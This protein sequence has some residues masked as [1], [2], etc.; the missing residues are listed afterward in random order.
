M[1]DHSP[2][3]KIAGLFEEEP[4]RPALSS[5][6]EQSDIGQVF[7]QFSKETQHM[8]K[9]LEIDLNEQ[10]ARFDS[11][12]LYDPD[13]DIGTFGENVKDRLE[14]D[15]REGWDKLLQDSHK[16]IDDINDDFTTL[17][18]ETSARIWNSLKPLFR[19]YE[20]NTEIPSPEDQESFDECFTTIVF[21][22][23]GKGKTAPK[24]ALVSQTELPQHGP[25]STRQMFLSFFAS[26]LQRKK[27]DEDD[28]LSV[29]SSS[30]DFAGGSSSPFQ[31][32][33]SIASMNVDPTASV[34]STWSQ[35]YRNSSSRRSSFVSP[36]S[37]DSSRRGSV[38]SLSRRS[39]QKSMGEE[40][41]RERITE[42]KNKIKDALQEMTGIYKK[43]EKDDETVPGA[44]E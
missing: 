1:T 21:D 34:F 40:E 42:Q 37:H 35:W 43:Y 33:D 13:K 38:A 10:A 19:L 28:P 6:A 36:K 11:I 9:G 3:T 12:P 23:I 26:R 2:S 18:P 14:D 27:K 4:D 41:A 16:C 17:D 31:R 29:S 7:E 5:S 24:D 44:E 20:G 8:L 25:G 15:R 30:V 32:R 22:M 39:T